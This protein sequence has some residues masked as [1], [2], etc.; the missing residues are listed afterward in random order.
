MTLEK[1]VQYKYKNVI[2]NI[3]GTLHNHDNSSKISSVYLENIL[4]DNNISLIPS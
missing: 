2:N 1:Q 3:I 4:K